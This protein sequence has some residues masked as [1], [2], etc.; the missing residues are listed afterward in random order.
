KLYKKFSNGEVYIDKETGDQI[1][2]V[3][4]MIQFVKSQVLDNKGRLGID[5]KA[6]GDAM[7][8]RKGKVIKG[9]WSRE[10]MDSPTIFT[11]A[12][13]KEMKMATGNTWIQVLDQNHKIEYNSDEEE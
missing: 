5:M 7:L 2:A 4:V 6:G 8:F 12:N 13:G 9:T 1:T 11:A 10:D 3:N